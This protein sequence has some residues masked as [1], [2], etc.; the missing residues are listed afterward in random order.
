MPIWIGT[1]VDSKDRILNYTENDLPKTDVARMP[2]ATLVAA[3]ILLG[4]TFYTQKPVLDLVLALTA[5]SCVAWAVWRNK[6]AY[7]WQLLLLAAI[8][9]IPVSK[10]VEHQLIERDL[11][12][13]KG[14]VSNSLNE[15]AS[16]IEVRLIGNRYHLNSVA[17]LM[18]DN[19]SPTQRQYSQWLSQLSMDSAFS[20]LNI[21]ITDQFVITRVFPEIDMNTALIGRDLSAVDNQRD[22][23]ER[24]ANEG[25]PVLDGPLKVLQGDTAL[26]YR[27]PISG[28]PEKTVTGVLS[29]DKIL[30]SAITAATNDYR[31]RLTVVHDGDS[32]TLVSADGFGSQPV[33]ASFSM[34]GVQWQLDAE[35]LGGWTEPTFSLW[36]VRI[37]AG[38]IWLFLLVILGWQYRAMRQRDR[39]RLQLQAQER[40]LLEAQRLGRLGSWTRQRDGRHYAISAPL[41]ELIGTDRAILKQDEFMARIYEPEKEYYQSQAQSVLTGQ[42][43]YTKFEHRLM[44]A[45]R[46]RWVE[47][48]L[49]LN[50]E[51]R[52]SGML[53]DITDI[54]TTEAELQKLAYYDSLTGASNRNFFSKQVQQGI[55]L[56]RRNGNNLALVLFDLDNFKDINAQYGH[57]IGDEVLKLLTERLKRCVRRTDTIARLSGDTFAV[58][59]QNLKDPSHTIF[60]ADNLLKSIS[61][62]LDVDGH[63]ITVTGTLGIATCP[64]DDFDYEGLV[65]KAEMA[66]KKAKE[67]DRGYYKFYSDQLNLEND[68]RQD[69]LRLL[70]NALYNSEF[71]LVLQP[72][73]S[74]DDQH[75]SSLE[76][77]IR[78][79]SEALGFVSPGEFIPIAEGSHM[80][81]DIGYW[82]I[83]EALSQF[84]VHMEDLDERTVLSI[85]LS[86]KQLEH[87][88]LIRFVASEL[89]DTGVPAHRLEFEITEHSLT[90][91]TETILATLT[92][93][94]HM[95]VRFA[96]DDFGTG[97]SNLGMLQALPLNV[98]KIDQRFVQ[99]IESGGRNLELV[100]AIIDM[101]HTLGLTVVAE[102]V[103]TAEQASIL[104]QMDCDELQG[105]HFYRPQLFVALM[106]GLQRQASHS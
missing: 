99:R 2:V 54:K 95:G 73:V 8:P 85:N 58:C 22:A 48:T 11:S 13:Q 47:H 15:L 104:T 97:Y 5:A 96:M 33:Q 30:A 14:A 84:A 17:L 49:A 25:Q 61:E 92:E 36:V 59:L 70:P 79:E 20:Y 24:V 21:A 50:G 101:G 93:L 52:L 43:P 88:D 44:T 68:R 89:Q 103:E 65:K 34:D 76:V 9:V 81:V 98:L 6:R 74:A 72:R 67:V 80:I 26:V 82:V 105:F 37:I 31:M 10:W 1:T 3:L 77:L 62:T 23:L 63:R 38:I 7:F 71:H 91:E 27:L 90:E 106:S 56:S 16:D 45:D 39:E 55:S 53:R 78:W 86:P 87:R 32:A 69:I 60:V 29:L 28:Q 46:L 42:A 4:A 19:P 18:A 41:G 35:P 57:T 12:Q 66:L 51:G 83:R 102:G 64:E 94:S 100:R 40:E 75:W